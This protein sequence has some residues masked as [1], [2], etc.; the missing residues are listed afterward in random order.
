MHAFIWNIFK[1]IQT[2][3]YAEREKIAER[4]L[5]DFRK[6]SL[7]PTGR[8]DPRHGNHEDLD[9]QVVGDSTKFRI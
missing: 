1:K 8:R 3:G 9:F 5:G 4:V 2:T 7:T 6:Y